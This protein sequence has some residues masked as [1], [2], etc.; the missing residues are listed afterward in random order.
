MH[1]TPCQPAPT[2]PRPPACEAAQS[3]CAF[4]S[5]LPLD[6]SATLPLLSTAQISSIIDAATNPDLSFRAI[7][8]AHGISVETL[9]LLLD[10]PDIKERIAVI[11]SSISRRTQ[12][13]AGASL[14]S[15]VKALTRAVDDYLR[16]E[17]RT[18]DSSPVSTEGEAGGPDSARPDGVSRFAHIEQRRRATETM[19]RAGL[20]LSR[21][22]RPPAPPRP[23]RD[24]NADSPSRAKTQGFLSLGPAPADTRAPTPTNHHII[25]EPSA[26]SAPPREPTSDSADLALLRQLAEA[27]QAAG[28]TLHALTGIPPDPEDLDEELERELEQ[29]LEDDTDEVELD[30]GEAEVDDMTDEDVDNL[31]E[32]FDG[33]LAH[34]M[35]PKGIKTLWKLF[36]IFRGRN[37]LKFTEVPDEIYQP[38]FLF[39]LD[40][41]TNNDPIQIL[42]NNPLGPLARYL[43]TTYPTRAGPAP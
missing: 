34:P 37:G 33:P 5:T 32:T 36:P 12:S 15:V 9:A 20:L 41:L 26:P 6:H 38:A 4:S 18:E 39:L 3:S 29:E 43:A 7:A 35:I 28:R 14:P 22:S 21:L 11:D 16:E 27:R 40:S 10:R 13:L 25:D 19:R 42:P 1:P 24:P 2:Q 8:Q 30:L 31:P 17:N 23:P